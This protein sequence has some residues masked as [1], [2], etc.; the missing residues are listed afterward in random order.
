MILLDPRIGS[1]H[2]KEPLLALGVPVDDS[3]EQPSGDAVIIGDGV[4]I[5]V[6]IKKTSDLMRSIIDGR[7]AGGQLPQMRDAFGA[8]CILLVE[9]VYRRGPFGELQVLMGNGFD[10]PKWALNMQ[11]DALQSWMFTMRTRAR[12]QIDQTRGK[13][14]T[15][16]W[17]ANLHRWAE[18]YPE[19]RSH[20]AVDKSHLSAFD[21]AEWVRHDDTRLPRTVKVAM[22]LGRGLGLGLEKAKAAAA[23]FT[24]PA[25]MIGASVADWCG[26]KGVGKKIA[27]AMVAAA[28]GRA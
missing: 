8:E 28:E 1:G 9:G 13:D 18:K 5:G 15:V 23:H 3:A 16:R 4:T 21:E 20:E 22:E 11:F 26:V 10:T 12:L 27:E 7:F 17:L 25:R 24:T 2:Y 6:E 14:E 19:H